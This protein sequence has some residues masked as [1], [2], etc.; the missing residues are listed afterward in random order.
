MFCTSNYLVCKHNDSVHASV[1]DNNKMWSNEESRWRAPKRSDVLSGEK[2]LIYRRRWHCNKETWM[3]FGSLPQIRRRRPTPATLFRLTDHP[4]PEEDGGSQWVLGENGAL[5]SKMVTPYQPP[6]LKDMTSVDQDD[7]PS[8]ED[9]GTENGTENT[10]FIFIL[11]ITSL[12]MICL[13]RSEN[14]KQ[15]FGVFESGKGQLAS[16]KNG[17]CQRERRRTMTWSFVCVC[18]CVHG[19]DVNT[20]RASNCIKNKVHYSVRIV[21]D[22]ECNAFNVYTMCHLSLYNIFTYMPYKYGA[23]LSKSYFNRIFLSKMR[24]WGPF[25]ALGFWLFLLIYFNI[26]IF[27]YIT[28]EIFYEKYIYPSTSEGT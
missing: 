3:R 12:N 17:G 10:F 11:L 15:V 19:C 27:F 14:K 8:G 9:D 20:T 26:S 21:N 5:K 16:G 1:N 2:R 18:V 28:L 22:G 4:S 13:G 23:I 6:S 7:P 24:P 25:V